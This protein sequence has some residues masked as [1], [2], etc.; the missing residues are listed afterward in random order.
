M[1]GSNR[2]TRRI[3]A[4]GF[5]PAMPAFVWM[6]LFFA[7]PL[8]LIA[9]YS[10]GH[11]PDFLTPISMRGLSLSSYRDALSGPFLQ[12]FRNTL[13]I[14]VVGTVL[15]LII[16]FPFA[17][18]VAVRTAPRW[19]GIAIG[20]V[21]IPFWTS[22]LIRTIGWRIVLSPDGW[23]SNWTQ[24]VG[25]RHS[26][27]QILDT[28][29]AVQLGVVYNYLPLMILPLF[30]ALSRLDPG[31]REVSR[32]L[33]ARPSATLWQVTLPLAMPGVVAGCL[34]VFI[35]LT[36]DYITATVLGGARGNMVGQ[37]VASQFLVAQDWAE[38]SALAIVL[39][40]LT[41]CLV[42]AFAIAGLAF[43]SLFRHHR[44]VELG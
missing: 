34:L 13:T 40:V 23:L 7:L 31:L 38:G 12:T 16:G 5:A 28:R 10:L 18:S 33:G 2:R 20:L 6:A 30:V 41:M 44:A 27:I 1:A 9:Y 43:R 39:I 26:P 4:P 8:S 15:C 14:A 25:L 17:Y 3:R 11:K 36:G 21:M 19:R 37:L 35:P 22:F 42:G 32:D 29:Y 24:S